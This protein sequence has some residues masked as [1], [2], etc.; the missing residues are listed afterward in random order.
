MSIC[1]SVTTASV[2][3]IT[4]NKLYSHVCLKPS[5]DLDSWT[6]EA[7]SLSQKCIMQISSSLLRAVFVHF[8]TNGI[9]ELERQL[10]T[11]TSY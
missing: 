2:S 3:D 4:C 1:L 8:G 7:K 11:D 5:M 9:Q 10:V 6:F